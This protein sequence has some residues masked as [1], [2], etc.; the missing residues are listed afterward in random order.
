MKPYP[1]VGLNHFTVPVA[2]FVSLYG[3]QVSD[4]TR[5]ARRIGIRGLG[6]DLRAAQSGNLARQTENVAASNV[7]L[8]QVQ[9]QCGPMPAKG[10]RKASGPGPRN[11][12][13]AGRLSEHA[14][15]TR[16]NLAF[17]EDWVRSSELFH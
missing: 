5:I 3:V 13:G 7:Q 17:F 15:L 9:R 8:R 16:P 6:N 11:R 2:I 4:R 14:G 10:P 1:L 12:T